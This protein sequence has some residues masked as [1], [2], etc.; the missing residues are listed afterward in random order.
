MNMNLSR[1]IQKYLLVFS[2]ILMLNA[3]ND[4]TWNQHYDINQAQ[5]SDKTLWA[6]LLE[7][8]SL[9]AFREVLD[10]VKVTNGYKITSVRYSDLLKEQYFT[11]FAPIDNSFNK[12]TL[13]AMCATVEGNKIVEDHF[14]MSH[15]TR[16][17]YSLSPY[18]N[19]MA[20]MLNGK[21]LPF[22]DSTLAD[23]PLIPSQSNIVAKNGLIHLVNGQIPFMRNIYENI[24]DLP[25]FSGMGNYLRKYQKDSL[26]EAASLV[27]GVNDMGVLVYIDSVIIR[28]N[29]LLN[30]FGQIDSEDSTFHMVAPSKVGW[31][32][33]YATVSKYFNFG[34]IAGGDSLR[35][36]WT[37]FSLMKDL[38][39]NWTMQ[40]SPSDSIIST[41][42]QY[43]LSK[44]K[45]HVFYNPFSPNGVLA[46]AQEMKASNGIL[47]KVNAWPYNM[48]SVFFTP[49]VAEAESEKNIR[50]VSKDSFNVYQR[51]YF[52]D[53]VSNNG[54]LDVNPKTPSVQTDV[55]F[56]IPNTLSGKYDVCAVILPRNITDRTD[57]RGNKFNAY[58]TYN[59]VNG[60][61]PTIFQCKSLSG[62]TY[63]TNKVNKVDTVLL[64]TV[65]LPSCNYK[66]NKVTVTLRLK[67][68]VTQKEINAKTFTNQMYIDCLYLK[69]RQN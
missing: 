53:S 27:A 59:Q 40:L 49:I 32:A 68:I 31:D 38:F 57:K 66:Q 42:Y 55:T 10:S 22:K 15:L 56:S 4:D 67:S 39:F 50:Y 13:L 44:Q 60:T 33:G 6:Q 30:S 65:S 69:P 12:D 37:N 64:T 14:I 61:T 41:Q 46:G 29:Q 63:F 47:Y 48:E 2:V 62:L 26:N 51:Q 5:T 19:K 24:I 1:I 43:W 45:L 52:A 35:T 8:D 3:C 21:Y 25:E 16:T 34:N 17:P 11:V 18:T 54:Y 23:V 9:S 28:K 20:H 36:Y 7:Q 58:L